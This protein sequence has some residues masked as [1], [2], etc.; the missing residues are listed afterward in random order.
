ME[1]DV[2]IVL[3]LE[4]EADEMWSYAGKKSN[5]IWLW[6]IL[7]HNTGE[8]IAYCFGT[9]EHAYLDELRDILGLCFV[10]DTIYTD[11]NPAYLNIT[12]SEVVQGKHN[13][14]RIEG[15][16]TALRTWCSRLVRK[17]IRFSKTVQMHKIAVGLVINYW[18][19]KRVLW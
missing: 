9:R 10:I 8:P 7:D 15:R 4:A 13:T 14:Q 17:T 18:F 3:V 2:D 1:I 19:F 5:Q 11:G 16:H 12:E 6:W